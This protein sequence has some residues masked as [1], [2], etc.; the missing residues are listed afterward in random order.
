VFLVFDGGLSEP[1]DLRRF[2]KGR[3]SIRCSTRRVRQLRVDHAAGTIVWPSAADLAP[4][5]L[6]LLPADRATPR[7]APRPGSV[8][9][10]TQVTGTEG[11]DS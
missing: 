1:V 7:G 4:E 2:L 8:A 6:Y 9:R 5:T 10:H 11:L 3:C